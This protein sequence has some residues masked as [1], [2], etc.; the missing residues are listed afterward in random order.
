V[1]AHIIP[2]KKRKAIEIVLAVV[3]ALILGV[4]T[5]VVWWAVASGA[6]DIMSIIYASLMTLGF[7]CSLMAAITGHLEWILLG[8]WLPY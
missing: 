7:G 2:L 5:V 4:A 6:R 3:A 8:Y 1:P